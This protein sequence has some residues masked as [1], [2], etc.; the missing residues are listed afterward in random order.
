MDNEP[1]SVLKK[2]GVTAENGYVYYDGDYDLLESLCDLIYNNDSTQLYK[3]GNNDVYFLRKFC[4]GKFLLYKKGIT[5]LKEVIKQFYYKDKKY[6]ITYDSNGEYKYGK[7]ILNNYNILP[8]N[9]LFINNIVEKI[10]KHSNLNINLL[11][12]GEPGTGKSS[13]V[14]IIAHK[15]GSNV[16][17]LPVNKEILISKALDN[18]SNKKNTILLIPEIDKILDVFGNPIHSENEFYELLDGSRTPRGSIIIMTCNNIEL[19]KKNKILTRPGRIHFEIEFNR[20][21]SSD[22]E[23]I[24]KKYYPDHSD[25]SIFDKYVNKVTHAEFH[26]AVCQAYIMN[27]DIN[28]L[29]IDSVQQKEEKLELYY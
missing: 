28:K 29:K 8:E 2:F 24:I 15:F 13:F 7:K 27:K 1:F 26:T 18:I 17:I 25:F 3:L 22:I 16:C 14:E 10:K 11:L 4:S 21:Q 23:F 6:Y 12:H 5:N 19:L 20:I 9:E